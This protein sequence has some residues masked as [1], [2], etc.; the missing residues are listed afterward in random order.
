M[1]CDALALAQ[2]P[3]G[4]RDALSDINMYLKLDDTL[5]QVGAAS[6]TLSSVG[7]HA[8]LVETL[9]KSHAP[10]LRLLPTC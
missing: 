9:C 5:L 1:V 10:A 7:S 2:E 3:L 4:L 8:H 6:V